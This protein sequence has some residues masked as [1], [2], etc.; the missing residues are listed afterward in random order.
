MTPQELIAKVLAQRERWVDVGT[1]KSVKV[2]RPAETELGRMGRNLTLER[3]CACVVDWRGF[4]LADAIGEGDG[5]IEFDAELWRVLVE[6]NA[7]W[8]NTVA[9]AVAE[10]VGEYTRNKQAAL[11]N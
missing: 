4:T 9:T 10:I 1:G 11:G 2:R 7:D 8:A 6:D 5:P 3:L